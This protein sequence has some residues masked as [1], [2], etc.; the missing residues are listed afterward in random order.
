[1]NHCVLMSIV[2][3]LLVKKTRPEIG[4]AWKNTFPHRITPQKWVGPNV[5][6]AERSEQ[7]TPVQAGGLA[8]THAG[9]KIRSLHAVRSSTVGQAERWHAGVDP[10]FSVYD[11]QPLL[12]VGT[13]AEFYND[14]FR[15][16]VMGSLASSVSFLLSDANPELYSGLPCLIIIVCFRAFRGRN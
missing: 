15:Y 12:R 13:Q 8:G 7:E 4:S 11:A 16:V 6:R 14:L 3:G 1:M 5:I 2:C 10:A 9:Q